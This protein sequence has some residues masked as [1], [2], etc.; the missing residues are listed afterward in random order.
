MTIYQRMEEV[1]RVA[2][3]PG[4]LQAWRKTDESP[5]LPDL[6]AIYN[7][8]R[9]RSAQSADDAEIFRRFD[10]TIW[11]YGTGDITDAAA[12]IEDAL[13]LEGFELPGSADGFA[14]VNGEHIYQKT[15]EAVYID[16]GEYGR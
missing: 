3:V 15:I 2:D 1:F 14:K 6:Y 8:T 16:F 10:V 13:G 11:L 7:L 5:E 12:R 9:E 4:F